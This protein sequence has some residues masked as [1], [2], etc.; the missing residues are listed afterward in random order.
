M[1]RETN[2]GSAANAFFEHP[3]LNS[4]FGPPEAYFELGP[5]GR[6]GTTLPGRRPSE[7][8]IPVP[9]SRKRRAEEQQAF[10]FDA[11]GERL[12]MGSTTGGLWVSEDQGGRWQEVTHTLPPIYAVAFA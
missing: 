8:F 6:T 3:I 1:N 5:H 9:P 2:L 7:S 12:A 11:T 10:D 4:P